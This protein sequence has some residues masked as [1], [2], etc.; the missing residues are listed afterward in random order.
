MALYRCTRGTTLAGKALDEGAIVEIADQDVHLVKDFVTL[1]E[2]EAAP[3][4]PVSEEA[5]PPAP[6]E[7]PTD[8]SPDDADP[9]PKHSKHAKAKK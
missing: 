5:A 3:V 7:E 9:A 2:P 6:A 4:N 8:P 1:H